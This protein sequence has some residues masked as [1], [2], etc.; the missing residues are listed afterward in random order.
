MSFVVP[1]NQKE[2]HNTFNGGLE[3]VCSNFYF[4]CNSCKSKVSFQGEAEK[5]FVVVYT[6]LHFLYNSSKP[7]VESLYT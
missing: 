5:S 1:G 2:S 4:V 3:I 6:N 7:K